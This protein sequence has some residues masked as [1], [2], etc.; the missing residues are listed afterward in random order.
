MRHTCLLIW[1]A[2]I[3]FVNATELTFELPDNE[4]QCFYEDLDEEAKFEI[5]FQVIAGGNYDVDCF[6]TDP[7]NNVLYQERKK[8]YDSF[9]HTT[10]MKGVYKVCF[11]NEFSTFSHKTVYLDFRTGEEI[12]LLPDM[13]RATALTQ[14]ESACMSIHEILKVV[15]DSQTWYR[16]RETQ[17]RIRAEDLNERVAYWSIGEAIILFVVSISQVLMLKSFFNEKKTY[18]ATST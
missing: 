14:M 4:K 18:G 16:L 10:T 17:D 1:A 3:F 6:V 9:S 13:N 11:S 8:Q 2:Y 12:P 5:D 7:M 15:A